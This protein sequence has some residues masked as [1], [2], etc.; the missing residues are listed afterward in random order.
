MAKNDGTRGFLVGG[1]GGQPRHSKG[2]QLSGPKTRKGET[3]EIDPRT[4]GSRI[5]DWIGL[6]W[7]GETRRRGVT[8]KKREKRQSAQS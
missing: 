5:G 6:D 7:I 2:R 3:S 4:R 8:K 1:G